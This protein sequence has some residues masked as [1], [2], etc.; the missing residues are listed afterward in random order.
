MLGRRTFITSAVAAAAGIGVAGLEL[1]RRRAD[2]ATR[3]EDVPFSAAAEGGLPLVLVNH[4]NRYRNADM[5]LYIVGT[6]LATGNQGYVTRQGELRPV[7]MDLNGSDG[8]ADLSIPLVADGDTTVK[9]PRMSGRVYVSIGEKLRFKAVV[10]GAGRPALQ[11]PAA[12]VE[13]DP[14]FRVLHDCME[15]THSA[16]GMFCNTTTV[17][18]LSV[19][20][21]IRLRGA[22]DQTTGTLVPG[23]RKRIFEDIAAAPGFERLVIDDLRV[24]APGHGLDTGRFSSTYLDS[25]ITRTWDAY[26]GRDLVVDTGNGKK[27]TGR[28]RDGV[29]QFSD[30]ANPVQRP[31]TRDVLFCDGALQAPNDGVNGPI[32]AVLGAGLNR[33]VLADYPNQPV[34]DPGLY[35]KRSITN[36]YARVM[37]E[38]TA[39]HHAYGFAFDDVCSLA[40]YVEDSAPASIT[41]RLTPFG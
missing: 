31:S 41:L 8:W 23:G 13:S 40:S 17:D 5:L 7:S 24:L 33:S 25:E 11:Y 14:S 2:A 29:L 16:G 12:W 9:L 34:T 21:E 1:D 15:F 37:H 26:T 38:N 20:M 18:M 22:K 27:Y 28:V 19:P 3:P 39:D 36:H 6:D 30:G 10:D 32:R 35:Y 4:T